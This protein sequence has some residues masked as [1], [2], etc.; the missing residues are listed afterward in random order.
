MKRA[1]LAFPI[2]LASLL[3]GCGGETPTTP[4]TMHRSTPT[5][6]TLAAS[7][8]VTSFALPTAF[9]FPANLVSGPDGALWFTETGKIGRITT[10]GALQEFAL[11]A[12]HNASSLA[13]GPDGALWFTEPNNSAVGRITTSGAV[14]EIK[15]PGACQVGYAC[16]TAP[17]PNGIVAGSDGALWI[18][19]PIFSRVLSRTS[20]AKLLRLTTSGTFTEFAIPG[21]ASKSTT[22]NP[23]KVA[24]GADGAV[25]FTDSFERRIWRATTSGALSS[26]AVGFG[27]PVAI[28]AGRDGALWFTANQLGR[29]STAGAVSSQAVQFG[30][31]GGS[32]GAIATASDGSLWFAA[33]DMTLSAGVIVRSTTAGSMSKTSFPTFVEIDGI[34]RGPDGAIWFTQTDNQTGAA[35]IGRLAG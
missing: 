33:Y 30:A 1:L 10:A 27:A 2:A 34:T 19:E 14:S 3:A 15:V 16:P 23:G 25:W 22:P 35:K 13:V 20:S 24:L 29:I 28:A 12:G 8:P 31:N 17:R 11:P 6:S 7:A 32:L 26:F 9:S 4:P 21:G 18:T 5:A